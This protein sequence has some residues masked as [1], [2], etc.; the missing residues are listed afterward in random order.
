MTRRYAVRWQVEVEVEADDELMARSM[1][2]EVAAHQG[3][4]TL[5]DVEDRGPA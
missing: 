5:E 1:A 3:D 2:D 4:W